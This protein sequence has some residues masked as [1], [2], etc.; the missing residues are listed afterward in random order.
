[1]ITSFAAPSN[2]SISLQKRGSSFL[3]MNPKTELTVMKNFTVISLFI[4]FMFLFFTIACSS[5]QSSEFSETDSHQVENGQLPFI[6]HMSFISRYSKKLYFAGEAENWELADIYSHEIEAISEDIIEM[7]KEHAGINIS[8]LM[9]SMLLPQIER[10]EEAIENEDRG[11]FLERYNVLIQT[12]NQCH[13]ATNYDAVV[14]TVPQTN[15]FNQ[16]FKKSN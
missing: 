8:E 4:L 6:Y 13:A 2:K 7:N 11:A 10:V 5:G 15:P 14:I 16:E 9:E 12:C 1:M 3:Q